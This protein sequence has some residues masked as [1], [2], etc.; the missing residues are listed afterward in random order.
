MVNGSTDPCSP[1]R[2]ARDEAALGQQPPTQVLSFG[3]CATHLD[4]VGHAP[5]AF[6]KFPARA[7]LAVG[8]ERERQVEGT[9]LPIALGVDE[10]RL[11]RE[12]VVY[13]VRLVVKE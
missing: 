1:S 4:A 13:Q 6:G 8:A 2:P 10:D 7:L 12:V 5:L 9:E 3:R 11:D